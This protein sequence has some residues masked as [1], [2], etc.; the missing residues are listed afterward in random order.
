MTKKKRRLPPV[1]IPDVPHRILPFNGNVVTDKMISFSFACFDR[2]HELFN[3]GGNTDDGVI[4]GKWFVELLDCLKNVGN[5]TIP[6][7]R[8]SKTHELHPIDWEHIK[9]TNPPKNSEQLEF[10]QFRI[11]K[12]KGRVI[13]FILE[14]VFYVVWLDPYHNLVD[15]EGYGT[16]KVYPPFTL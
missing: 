7:M 3:L 14:N 10:W 16:I 15:S 13:G 9:N 8:Q 11:S 4:S 5:M 1:E 6:E 12:S 2:S